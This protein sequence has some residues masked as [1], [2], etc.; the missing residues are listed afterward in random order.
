MICDNICAIATPYGMGAISIIRTSGP[1]AINLVSK[2]FK[3]TNLNN[4]K[5]HTI[6]LGYIMDNSEIIDEVLVSVFK[7]PKSF[8]GENSVEI[9]CHGGV[10]VTN[11]VLTTL[12]TNGFRMA[13]PGEFSR[14][15]FL[16]KRMDLTQSESIMDIISAA[17]NNA[18]KSG[19]NTLR[20][21]TKL[22][23]TEFRNL[24]LDLMAKIEVNID[25]PEYEDSEK[26]TNEVII[27]KLNTIIDRMNVII[28]NSN[29]S[30]IA[31][32]GINVAIVGK[33]NVGK[34]SLL[35]LLLDEDKAIVSNIPGTTRDIVE[36]KL[37]IGE[38]T[39]NLIDTAGIRKSIDYVE[40]IGIERS[41]KAIEK[42]DL[43]LVVLDQSSSLTEE[44]LELLKATENKKRIIIGNKADLPS[45]IKDVSFI[46]LSVKD[47]KGLEELMNSIISITKVN[48]F[49]PADPNYISNVR[50]LDLIRKAKESLV[51]AYNGARNLVPV[52]M[53]EIDIKKAFDDL[54]LIT[55]EAYEDELI[56]SLFSKFC[57]GK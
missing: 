8:D 42:A 51:D 7:T 17:N 26:I 18:L 10:L 33:P 13:L 29:I 30:R 35:N 4:V 46:S 1:D 15:A 11:K 45:K 38:V 40:Q 48:E 21:K 39:L 43:V 20:S 56:D 41:L 28:K 23:I 57:L 14:R 36:G 27:P 32:H 19:I 24:L 44:D 9:S 37:N 34:S 12:L 47:N 53:V 3:G 55:G 5:S 16:N 52:D 22:L 2:V 6:H 25:Y 54:G 49:N 31:C 50:H